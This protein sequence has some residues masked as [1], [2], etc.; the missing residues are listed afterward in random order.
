MKYL[1]PR[2][3]LVKQIKDIASVIGENVG[4]TRDYEAE[5]LSICYE[6]LKKKKKCGCTKAGEVCYKHL[7]TKEKKEIKPL[8]LIDA[9]NSPMSRRSPD[10]AKEIAIENKIN[11]IIDHLNSK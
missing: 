10:I 6:L 4:M 7:Q 2:L 1:N 9:V 3:P 11:E 5:L 8:R